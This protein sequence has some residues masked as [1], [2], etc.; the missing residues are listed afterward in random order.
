[1]HI[2]QHKHKWKRQIKQIETVPSVYIQRKQKKKKQK[3]IQ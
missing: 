3:T 2:D 1:M